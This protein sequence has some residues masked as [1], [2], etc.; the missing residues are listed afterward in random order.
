MKQDFFQAEADLKVDDLRESLRR[1][2]H[3]AS[4]RTAAAIRSEASL[5][6]YDIY[7]PAHIYTLVYG[8]KPTQKG[9]GGSGSLLDNIKAWIAS[10]NLDL[11][12]YAVT[13]KIHRDGTKLF[14]EIKQG[15]SPSKVLADVF[16]PEYNKQ[17]GERLKEEYVQELQSI[18]QSATG[19]KPKSNNTI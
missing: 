10:K 9:G 12:P 17:L 6:G 15:G 11:N 4:G 3:N 2:K 1:Y 18:M 8:R 14:V 13:A 19:I 16:G 7:G 5:E